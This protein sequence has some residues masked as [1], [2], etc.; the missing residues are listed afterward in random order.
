MDNIFLQISSLLAI[1]VAIAFFVRMMRQPLIVAYIVAGIVSGPMFLNLLHGDKAT[2]AMFAQFGVVLLLFAIGLNLN[3]NR[4]KT[5]GTISVFGGV[6]QLVFT[7]VIGTILLLALKFSFTAAFYLAVATTFSSTIVIVK[8]LADKKD[9]E[10]IYG[11]YTI[12][13]LLI[14]DL[15]A[16]LIM[17]AIGLLKVGG[18]V[19]QTLVFLIAKGI[20]AI[21]FIY[22][23]SKYFLPRFLDR[24]AHSSELLFI[25]TIT[26]CFGLS[27]L[28]YMLGFSVEIGAIAAGISLSSSPYQPEIASRI[29]PLRDFFLVLFFIVLGS[30]I[31]LNSL[32][33]VWWPGL[34]FSLFILIGN[35]I[36]LYFIYRLLKFT[37]R[38]SFL[39]AITA[40]QVSEFGFVMLYA[41]KQL[42]YVDSNI[43]SVFTLIAIV[44]IFTSSYLIL[45]NEAI[46]RAFI[47]FFELFGKDKH[48]QLNNVPSLYDV[49]LVGYHRIGRQ[50]GK[51]LKELH[52]KFAVIDFDPRV[53]R[54]MRKTKTPAFFGDVAD[55]EFLDDLPLPSAKM[56]V[57]TIPAVDDQVNLIVYVHKYNKDVLIIANAYHTYEAKALYAA[58]ANYVMMPHLLGGNWI[59][60]MLKSKKWTKKNLLS[61]KKEQED[62]M[63]KK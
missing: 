47:P 1:T 32:N 57:M 40:A 46:Y 21:F 19:T 43:V 25:F 27:S 29:K 3:F 54:E 10:T 60:E 7:A 37:R 63:I 11:K 5:I 55:I 24:I 51:A 28:L 33:A 35:P 50:V 20:W 6:G 17:V 56:I 12:G 31:S 13:L 16:L 49:W 4:L 42:G 38:N 2:Y 14:Q 53:I 8:L 36:I 34:I 48:R 61:L 15:I 59:A 62:L 23:F 30:E 39:I 52:I 26:W 45:Y 18:E 58:G 44:T 41:A 9:T 22:L